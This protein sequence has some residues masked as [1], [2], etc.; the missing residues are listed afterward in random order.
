L[1]PLDLFAL[2]VGETDLYKQLE[3][4]IRQ[5]K[6]LKEIV[7]LGD[8]WSQTFSRP[9]AASLAQ[10]V[11]AEICR[12]D[13]LIPRLRMPEM[14][15]KNDRM[16]QPVSRLRQLMAKAFVF[17]TPLAFLAFEIFIFCVCRVQ[18]M[19]NAAPPQGVSI[20]FD[21]PSLPPQPIIAEQTQSY[22]PTPYTSSVSSSNVA[23]V[24]S[25]QPNRKRSADEMTSPITAEPS[26]KKSKP[27]PVPE[28]SQSLV[29][30][31]LQQR[32]KAAP[33]PPSQ[34]IRTFCGLGDI[35]AI[36]FHPTNNKILLI[37]SYQGRN[38]FL[39]IVD[40]ATGAILS[41][42]RRPKA[43]LKAL[44]SP[45]GD[46]VGFNQDSM[47]ELVTIDANFRWGTPVVSNT[48][49]AQILAWEFLRHKEQTFIFMVLKNPDSTNMYS[50]SR[51]RA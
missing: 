1:D 15:V 30:L 46:Y 29:S 39:F 24:Q 27:D 7:G 17:W 9:T 10:N 41:E 49:R 16:G 6:L 14:Q 37:T 3:D 42:L 25:P 5:R 50:H 35:K 33:I 47:F 18:Q 21:P 26:A 51:V 38:G 48:D 31:A 43:I 36:N 40:V 8:A 45:K 4:L 32:Q 22:T 12:H 44:F 20:Y 2:H 19:Y 13:A 11:Q 28:V 23:S 34:L